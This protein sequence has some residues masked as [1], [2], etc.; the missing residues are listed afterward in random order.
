MGVCRVELE[1]WSVARGLAAGGYKIKEVE[2]DNLINK[3]NCE[4]LIQLFSSFCS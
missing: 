1:V 3:F 2:R 4:L